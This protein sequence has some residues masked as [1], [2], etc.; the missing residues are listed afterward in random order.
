[1]IQQFPWLQRLFRKFQC[2]LKWDKG[3]SVYKFLMRE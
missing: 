1:M 2:L 3:L